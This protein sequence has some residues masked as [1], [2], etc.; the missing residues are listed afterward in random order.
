MTL[1]SVKIT[2]KNHRQIFNDD[3]LN[4]LLQNIYAKT[5]TERIKEVYLN[6]YNLYLSNS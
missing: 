6:N 3:L 4:Q 1:I 2:I 5:D